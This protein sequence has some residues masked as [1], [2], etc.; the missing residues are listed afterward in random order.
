M[1]AHSFAAMV[2]VL[3]ASAL[4]LYL[5]PPTLLIPQ[6]T[7]EG[8]VGRARHCATNERAADLYRALCVGGKAS[9]SNSSQETSNS[10]LTSPRALQRCIARL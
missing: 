7:G 9:P 8:G 10:S 1:L 4:P 5:A 3:T 6:E 2:V